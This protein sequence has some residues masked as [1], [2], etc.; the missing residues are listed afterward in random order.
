VEYDLFAIRTGIRQL[1]PPLDEHHQAVAR[2][3]SPICDGSFG[4]SQELPFF[5]KIVNDAAW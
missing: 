1:D 5:Q 2:I 3:S 4:K